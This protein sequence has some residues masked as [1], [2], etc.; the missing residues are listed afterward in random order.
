MKKTWTLMS[1]LLLVAGLAA[2]GGGNKP[3][4]TPT[5]TP[6]PSE[7]TPATP[8]PTPSPSEST[9]VEE[10][11]YCLAGSMNGWTTGDLEYALT[12]DEQDSNRYYIEGVALEAGAEFKV[13]DTKGNWHPTGMGNN[14]KVEED[15]IY[16]IEFLKNTETITATKTGEYTPEEHQYYVV[17]SFNGWGDAV[18]NEDYLMHSDEEGEYYLT[19]EFEAGAELK[20]TD[21]KAG[22]WYGTAAGGNVVVTE[23]GTYCVNFVLEPA[24]GED[25]V[26][27]S[28]LK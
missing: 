1:A 23:A 7:S 2:C 22:S 26:T 12:K 3:V 6:T 28:E 21:E 5:P 16:T 13:T 17:G 11:T 4:P 14:S 19:L 25:P 9:P 24:E 18:G 10:I 8:T 20:V 15:G 27:L